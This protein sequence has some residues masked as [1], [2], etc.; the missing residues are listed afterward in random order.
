MNERTNESTNQPTNQKKTNRR[1]TVTPSGDNSTK[2]RPNRGNEGSRFSCGS[3]TASPILNAVCDTVSP[4]AND[5]HA[6]SS[7][8]QHAQR[9]R[10]SRTLV[11]LYDTHTHSYK[12]C[13]VMSFPESDRC[14]S[15]SSSPVRRLPPRFIDVGCAY[16][17]SV[18]QPP[19]RFCGNFF[20]NGWEFLVQILCASETFL[21]TLEYKF[22][23]NYLQLWW[24]YTIL[25]ASSQC[26]FRS[27][28]D[29]LS[30]MVVALNM[31]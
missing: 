31:A 26:A 23:F 14:I 28:A 8:S 3:A 19:L 29:I 10:R 13:H 30:T 2:S 11:N 20:S 7:Q 22:L 9:V 17:Y 5:R 27:M 21:P 18:S 15:N 6:F 16:Y 1:I 24:S 4:Y 12:P 25:S